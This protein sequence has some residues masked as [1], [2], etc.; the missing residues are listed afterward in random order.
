[1]KLANI[2]VLRL[3]GASMLGLLVLISIGPQLSKPLM[4][5]SMLSLAVLVMAFCI[6][7]FRE[8]PRDEREAQHALMG[9]QASYMV[10]AGIL[11]IGIVVESF[12]H[13]LDPY[14]PIALGAMVAA[15]L[16]STR[17]IQ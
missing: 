15:K 7:V 3:V 11:L 4:T 9:G 10:G 5:L 14:L 6:F 16:V 2:T 12:A 17:T 8:Q 1:M 13:D